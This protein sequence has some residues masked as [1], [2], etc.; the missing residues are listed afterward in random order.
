ML[1]PPARIPGSTPSQH[2]EILYN[3]GHINTYWIWDCHHLQHQVFVLIFWVTH[4]IKVWTLLTF[5]C[6]NSDM[7]YF[8][9]SESH[10]HCSQK[11]IFECNN[12][13][14]AQHLKMM[15]SAQPILWLW[16]WNDSNLLA[17]KIDF[18]INYV[19][20]PPES[21]DKLYEAFQRLRRYS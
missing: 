7:I 21:F 13:I 1:K 14:Y 20:A 8:G 19:E 16:T 5:A 12:S 4:S 11:L 6:E 3:I 15:V 17:F 18:S 2:P 9:L 10:V